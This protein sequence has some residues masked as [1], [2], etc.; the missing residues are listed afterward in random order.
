MLVSMIVAHDLNNGIG[1]DGKLLW[2]IPKDLKHFRK[3]TLGC[4]VVM[5]RKT[6][7]SLP[8]A[9]P[10]R[11]NWI[12][13]RDESY[14][15]KTRFNDKVRVFHSKEELLAEAH[16]LLKA[17]IFII[18]GGE[19]YNLFLED[20]TNIITTVVDEVFDADT[21]F[22]KLKH[23]EWERVRTDT[24]SETVNRRYYKFKIITMKRKEKK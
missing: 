14:I 11:E 6:Y 10:H 19:I 3:M 5:G 1:K 23:N 2:H 22:P 21:F 7:E 8:N 9:L 4:T 20:A 24:D 15:P 12:L 17:N 18:G 16:R 13:T